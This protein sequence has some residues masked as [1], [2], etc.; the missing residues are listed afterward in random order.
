VR[1]C[2][3]ACMHLPQGG[4]EGDGVAI[5]ESERRLHSLTSRL[6]SA[7]DSPVIF[8]WRPA[9]HPNGYS[10]FADEGASNYPNASSSFVLIV[11][12]D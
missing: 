5:K 6:V 12:S 7:S 8:L 11:F 10:T 9:A 2:V 1:A 4:A 3:R